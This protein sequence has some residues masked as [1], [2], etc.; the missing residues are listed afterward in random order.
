V[1]HTLGVTLGVTTVVTNFSL[2]VSPTGL[3]VARDGSGSYTVTILPA[4]FTGT[5]TLAVSG[6][7]KFATAK[8]APASIVNSGSS[9]LTISSNKKVA[10]GTSTLTITGTSG[11]QL[12]KVNL[13]FQ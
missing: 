4:G 7:P 8:F 6:L 3:T 11:V 13:T 9:T 12:A 1:S 5:V 2:S 10:Q